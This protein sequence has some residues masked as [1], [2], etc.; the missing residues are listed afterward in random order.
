[1][2]PFEYLL[3]LKLAPTFA[4]VNKLAQIVILFVARIYFPLTNEPNTDI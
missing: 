2:A 4:R 1:M 3:Q